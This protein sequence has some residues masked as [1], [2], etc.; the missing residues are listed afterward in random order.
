MMTVLGT[1]T[2]MRVSKVAQLQLCDALWRFDA[3]FHI[4]YAESLA[5]RIYKRKQDTA[6]KG[7]YPLTGSVVF[8]RLLDYT[9]R[10]G[11]Q[12]DEACTKGRSPCARCRSC[13]PLFPKIA[14][15]VVTPTPVSRQQVTNA[16]LERLSLI[17]VDTTHY[18]GISMRWGGISA[19]LAARVPEPILFEDR[20]HTYCYNP[21]LAMR[22]GDFSRYSKAVAS[23]KGLPSCLLFPIKVHHNHLMLQADNQPLAQ[24]RNTMMTVL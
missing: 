6:R 21:P 17:G 13:M 5:C 3:A 22:M 12:V 24:L 20:H 23:V 8:T 14:N 1:V 4:K 2:C 19:G 11:L 18:S 10:A 16:V 9:E 7:L 15:G